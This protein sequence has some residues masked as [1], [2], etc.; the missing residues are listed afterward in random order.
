[1]TAKLWLE[2][3]TS[4]FIILSVIW[5]WRKVKGKE[6]SWKPWTAVLTTIVIVTGLGWYINQK[7]NDRQKEKVLVEQQT[8]K[9]AVAQATAKYE[10][11]WKTSRGYVHGRTES[12]ANERIADAV[13]KS[14]GSIC[15]ELHYMEHG[16]PE[17]ERIRIWK[18]DDKLWKG[19]ADQ[20]NPESH[21]KLELVEATPG[22]YSGKI[23][24]SD[25]H[26]GT[27]YLKTL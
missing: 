22:L 11:Y 2:L 8:A 18:V 15:A 23:N 26:E 1:M 5:I 13:P 17:T 20:D 6:D 4:I 27:C 21:A 14:D 16:S 12:P 10:W 19:T 24:W 3:M 25:G 9:A 7:I